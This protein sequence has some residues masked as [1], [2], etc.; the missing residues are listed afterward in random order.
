MKISELHLS[1]FK[2]FTSLTVKDIPE[3]AKLVLLIGANGSGKSSVF[4]GFNLTDTCLG[5]E[6][7]HSTVDLEYLTK[8]SG[9]DGNIQITFTDGTTISTAFDEND[10]FYLEEGQTREFMFY[11]RTSFR[12]T[13]RLTRTSLGKQDLKFDD[14]FDRPE[15]FIDRDERFENDIEKIT[16]NILKALFREKQSAEAIN[17]KYIDPINRAFE[18]IFG[19]QNGT[20]LRLLEI[21]PPLEGKIAQITFEKGTS[22]FHYNYLSAGEKEVFNL[23]VNLLSRRDLYQDTIYYFDEIDLH[24]NTKLQ[25]RLLK[26]IVENWIPKNSQLW[27]AS[28]SLGFIEYARQSEEA[29]L[30]DFDELDFDQPQVLVPESKDNPEIYE[31][32]VSKEFLPSLFREMTVYFVENRDKD[33]YAL[34]KLDKSVFIPA[35]N[36]NDVYYKVVHNEGFKGIVDRDFLSDDDI[37]KLKV[38]YPR[39]KVL[40]YYCIENYLFHP[41]NLVEYKVKKGEPFDREAYIKKLTELKNQSVRKIIIGIKSIRYDY[42]YFDDPKFKDSLRKRFGNKKENDEQVERI[43]EAL[44]S[45]DF[46]RYYKF[47]SMK[48]Y[49]KQ[50]EERQNIFHLELA[51]TNWFQ[52]RMENLLK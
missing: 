12:Q 47:F 5:N 3:T 11:G 37:E 8:L 25:F 30:I 31:I 18:N 24:L 16:A 17:E 48:N 28:H 26:E 33:R 46:E 44:D 23:L 19:G 4:D 39:L 51:R 40:E 6:V 21:I 45:N 36:R 1:N 34:L 35:N 10:V 13:P 15:S 20:K 42:K 43:A 52:V 32:A 38:H 7:K 14:D 22:T 9:D 2:R 50:L 29:V 27:T 49:G 41:D